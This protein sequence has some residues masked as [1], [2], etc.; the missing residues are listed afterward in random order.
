MLP[1]VP[2]FVSPEEAKVTGFE[3]GLEQT[4]SGSAAYSLGNCLEPQFSSVK[5]G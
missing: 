2:Q 5:W 3:V 1:I 4:D